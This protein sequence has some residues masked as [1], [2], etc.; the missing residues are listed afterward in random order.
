MKKK[1]LALVCALTM[2]MGMSISVF[3]ASPQAGSI[4][5][6]TQTFGAATVE[7]FA[8][9]TTAEGATVA[10]VDFATASEAVAEAN[11][12]YGSSSFVATVVDITGTPGVPFTIK[13]PNVW[14]GQSVTVLHKVNG[15]WKQET[16]TSVA[17]NAITL[18]V[19][20]FSPFAVVIDT[21]AST[22]LSPKTRDI[23]LMVGAIAL[24]CVAGVVLTG[25]KKEA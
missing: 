2:V 16:V 19:D 7:N 22:A 4:S 9:V 21:S 6:G 18:T 14:A 8:K 13:N 24:V 3:A 15:V 10:A 23:V 5:T 12:L 20:S 11:A 1:V 25:K 17:D